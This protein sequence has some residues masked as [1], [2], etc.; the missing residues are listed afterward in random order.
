MIKPSLPYSLLS[1]Y[2]NEGILTGD[3][4]KGNCKSG[5][6]GEFLGRREGELSGGDQRACQ[7]PPMID[8][9][10]IDFGFEDQVSRN[11]SSEFSTSHVQ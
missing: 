10:S 8:Y 9:Q 7:P 2:D 11:R 1:N 3:E 4:K 6:F 5:E